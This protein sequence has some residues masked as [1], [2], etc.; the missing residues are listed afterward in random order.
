MRTRLA[1]VILALIVAFGGG[2]AHANWSFYFAHSHFTTFEDEEPHPKSGRMAV[3]SELLENHFGAIVCACYIG[4]F[5][6][7]QKGK[8]IATGEVTLADGTR[9]EF[10]IK[11]K[12]RRSAGENCEF[13]GPIDTEAVITMNFDFKGFAPLRS[14]EDGNPDSAFFGTLVLGHQSG[15]PPSRK[16]A[17]AFARRELDRAFG[18]GAP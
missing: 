3:A 14:P 2:A 4:T 6:T 10:R 11:V 1:W 8:I 9:E 12:V 7:P 16:A 15:P 18:E 5:E 13:F 17:R